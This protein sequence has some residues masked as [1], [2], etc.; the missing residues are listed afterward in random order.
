MPKV[1][2]I[3][4][5]RVGQALG[6][7]LARAGVRLALVAARDRVKARQA[8]RFIGAGRPVGLDS[9]EVVRADVLLIT[10]SDSALAEVSKALA[11]RRDDW[12]GAIV[13]R[14]CEALRALVGCV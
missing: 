12:R 6:R 4:P 11:K 13:I 5:G 9:P 1:A 3:G 14:N 10:T 7:L 8:A 2:L